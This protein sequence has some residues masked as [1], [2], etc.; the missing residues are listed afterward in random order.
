MQYNNEFLERVVFF[1]FLFFLFFTV[2]PCLFIIFVHLFCVY[3]FFFF[4]FFCFSL[5]NLCF[6]FFFFCAAVSIRTDSE[7]NLPSEVVSTIK[8]RFNGGDFTTTLFD[9]AKQHLLK[10]LE[11]QYFREFVQ[12]ELTGSLPV[13]SVTDD[14]PAQKS[15]IGN[16]TIGKPHIIG[17][18]KT[19][20]A[21][22]SSPNPHVGTKSSVTNAKD[23]YA[24]LPK[25]PLSNVTYVAASSIQKNKPTEYRKW[26]S[27]ILSF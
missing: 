16:A 13:G 15:P 5:W 14:V 24:S 12:T 4:P 9:P 1:I 27:I 8:M 7:L 23:Q 20:A 19:V 11:T 17:N 2:K 25:Q 10:L 21:G 3:K 18:L 26:N 22:T 6:F